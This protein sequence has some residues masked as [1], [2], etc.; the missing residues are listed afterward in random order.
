VIG[1][2][3]SL[4][5]EFDV[6]TTAFLRVEREHLVVD[7]SPQRRRQRHLA[8]RRAIQAQPDVVGGTSTRH[9]LRETPDYF[10]PAGKYRD[11]RDHPFSEDTSRGFA[12]SMSVS[13]KPHIRIANV[14]KATAAVSVGVLA[15]G[16]TA[17]LG[18]D[19]AL[20][21]NSA[22]VRG[23]IGSSHQ[24]PIVLPS[25]V[26][27]ASGSP[28]AEGGD[29]AATALTVLGLL[30]PSGVVG[31]GASPSSSTGGATTPARGPNLFSPTTIA[32]TALVPGGGGGAA[33]ADTN[34]RVAALAAPGA[35]PIGA[36]IAV[37]ISDGTAEH[38]DAGLLIGNGW[39]A[40]AGSGLNGGRGGLLIGN[41][42]DGGSGAPGQ[43][44]GNGGDGGLLF[45]NG[46][47]GGRG[48][49]GINGTDGVNPTWSGDRAQDGGSDLGGNGEDG[50]DGGPGIAGGNGGP[51]GH[52]SCDNCDATGG[53]GGDG[54]NGGA[55]APGGRGGNA[56]EGTAPDTH[57]GTGGAG[58]DGGNGGAG[59][60]GGNGGNGGLG[61]GGIA[62]GGAGGNGGDGGAGVPGQAGGAGGR[63]GSGGRGG[64]FGGRGGNGG[65]G[66]TG[67]T[68]GAGTDGGNG[69]NAG[70][71]GDFHTTL[72]SG[73]GG[74][75]GDPGKGGLGGAGGAGGTGG[76]GGQAG[77]GTQPGSQ[78]VNGSN[79]ATGTNG[80]TGATGQR[81]D[82]GVGV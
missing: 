75:P 9:L 81:G 61:T 70:D 2:L 31:S 12:V 51:G 80:A 68:G 49:D 40:P 15:L 25:P 32:R 50:D 10:P 44:G 71:G 54:G 48:G 16:G 33:A 27:T 19:V 79:G 29:K 13:A 55:G 23:S 52:N 77:G 53:N 67:G 5:T 21:A 78:G 43:A 63:G 39:S 28:I 42:G 24:P 41:G 17:A 69:G 4:A 82:G 20:H 73:G 62:E 3:Q 7:M 35:D 65:A 57:T 30:N 11:A 76:T 59:A 18:S 74:F 36:L 34:F 72:G 38:P 58:G 14:R 47:N 46:G 60:D 64:I 45:G 66:G 1:D 37:F 22:P 56:G 8:A 6:E 26:L